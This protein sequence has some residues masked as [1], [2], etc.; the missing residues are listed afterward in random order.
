MLLYP[1]V[2]KD[3]KLI[4]NVVSCVSRVLTTGLSGG[5][6]INSTYILNKYISHYDNKQINIKMRIYFLLFNKFVNNGIITHPMS[7]FIKPISDP[8][9][10]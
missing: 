6:F 1:E 8:S 9:E 5:F 3:A 4:S 7:C 2:C 10:T